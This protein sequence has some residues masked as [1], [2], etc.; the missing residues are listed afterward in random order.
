MSNENIIVRAFELLGKNYVERNPHIFEGPPGYVAVKFSEDSGVDNFHRF[1]EI[2]AMVRKTNKFVYDSLKTIY[3]KIISHAKITIMKADAK[4]F[5]QSVLKIVII[6]MEQWK[7]NKSRVD[8]NTLKA[9]EEEKDFPDCS[10]VFTEM[11]NIPDK[12]ATDRWI[13][14]VPPVM[15]I[16]PAA[17]AANIVPAAN[18]AP[19]LNIVNGR[20]LSVAL[21][22]IY[23]IPGYSGNGN[24]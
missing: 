17:P 13:P 8:K 3:M 24:L 5:Q 22:N 10:D 23:D 16:A 20:N 2:L 15:P 4:I 12:I 6:Q 14:P 18:T 11:F 9:F 21:R 1:L 19:I 7:L